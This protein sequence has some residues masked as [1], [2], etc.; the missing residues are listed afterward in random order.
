M[1]AP[2]QFARSIK[3]KA[4]KN[5]EASILSSLLWMLKDSKNYEE[6]EGFFII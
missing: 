2:L 6:L 4:K 1:L 3:K 5:C